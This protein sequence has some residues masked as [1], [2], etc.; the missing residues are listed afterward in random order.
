M[1]KLFKVSPRKLRNVNGIVISPEMG[2]VVTTKSHTN[3]PFCNGA[4]EVKESFM[5]LYGVE[6][7]K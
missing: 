5:R 3:D 4:V 7:N 2:V 6:L 1:V